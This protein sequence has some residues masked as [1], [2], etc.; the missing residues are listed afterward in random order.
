MENID[1]LRQVIY[2]DGLIK[3]TPADHSAGLIVVAIKFVGFTEKG[4]SDYCTY[5][6]NA[7]EDNSRSQ[8]A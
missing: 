1:Q 4:N 7:Q 8:A 6:S 5:K 3:Q 2:I